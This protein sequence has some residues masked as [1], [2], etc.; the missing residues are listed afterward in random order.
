MKQEGQQV[1]KLR[2]AEDV[3]GEPGSAGAERVSGEGGV[4]PPHQANRRITEAA[5]IGRVELHQVVI[6]IDS[7]RE[8]LRR[9]RFRWAT[10]DAVEA[11]E[12]IG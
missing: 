8:T 9:R 3:R 4:D 11:G 1:F 12:A 7:V 2:G 10:R 5:A 6:N